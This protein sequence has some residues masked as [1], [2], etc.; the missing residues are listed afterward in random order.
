MPAGRPTSYKKEYAEQAYK[1]CLLGATN[2]QLAEF[3][4]VSESTIDNWLKDKKEFLG[5]VKEGREIAD[6]RVG[7][8]LYQR[9]TG[10]QHEEDK[11]FCTDGKVTTVKTTK[12][13][14]PDATS[15]IFWL[16]N[17]QRDKWREKTEHEHSGSVSV[18][19]THLDESI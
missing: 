14:P 17:R 8:S 6:A 3:F 18:I 16:K 11:I 4:E 5:A 9:A 19:A 15:M 7:E 1:F 2:A 13:Y 12:H 10:Y